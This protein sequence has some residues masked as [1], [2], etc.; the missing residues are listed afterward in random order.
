M[1]G[2]TSSPAAKQRTAERDKQILEMRLRGATFEMIA[3]RLGM[4]PKGVS[5]AYYRELA[6]IPKPE[7]E[8][9]R[10][11]HKERLEE[12]EARLFG[13]DAPQKLDVDSTVTA[14]QDKKIARLEQVVEKMT[15]DERTQF[16]LLLRQARQRLLEN[17]AGAKV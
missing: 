4:H 3:G 1:G 11:E 12:R 9:L 17:G 5:K 2:D 8:L 10:K 14:D 13:L 15:D 6:N 7:R 16:L